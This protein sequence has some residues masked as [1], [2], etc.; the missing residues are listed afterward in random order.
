MGYRAG[1]YARLAAPAVIGV[2]AGTL[3]NLT[4][5]AYLPLWTAIVI[6]LGLAYSLL[7]RRASSRARFDTPPLVGASPR[8]EPGLDP[9]LPP[10]TTEPAREP[11]LTRAE[12]PPA[13]ADSRILP[14]W[15]GPQAR[16]P[17][18]RQTGGRVELPYPISALPVNEWAEGFARRVRTTILVGPDDQSRVDVLGALADELGAEPE[19]RTGRYDPELDTPDRKV[20]WLDLGLWDQFIRGWLFERARADHSVDEDWLRHWLDDGSVA[21]IIDGLDE[22]EPG[23]RDECASMVEELAS[24]FPAA[25]VVLACQQSVYSSRRWTGFDQVIRVLPSSSTGA[26]Q[27]IPGCVVLPGDPPPSSSRGPG[28]SSPPAAQPPPPWI[29]EERDA[30]RPDPWTGP[31]RRTEDERGPADWPG[32]FEP[33]PW[34]PDRTEEDRDRWRAP[35]STY[36]QRP[37]TLG[38]GYA[39]YPLSPA[40]QPGPVLPDEQRRI[41]AAMA[42]G[43][44]YDVTQLASVARVVPS[45]L[46]DA[47]DALMNAGLVVEDHIY[48]GT[49]Y[50]LAGP[51]VLL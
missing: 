9:V 16:K 4:P 34:P 30:S 5:F 19:P 42:E 46:P 27:G 33:D 35:S 21:L 26:Y 38:Q 24:D 3:A 20:L 18:A 32:T 40:V 51:D 14:F 44:G 13:A 7:G 37:G 47:L 2:G 45:A 1:R 23:L 49:R 50:R 41:V 12:P 11:P 10:I 8:P 43:R 15:L 31:S 25:V 22:I 39:Q 28:S 6:V 29:D 48:G 17:R 36:V